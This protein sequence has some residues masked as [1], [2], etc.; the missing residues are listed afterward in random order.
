M[1]KKSTVSSKKRLGISSQHLIAAVLMCAALR[2]KSKKMQVKYKVGKIK[3]KV[4]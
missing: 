1:P 3:Y 2:Y 4:K